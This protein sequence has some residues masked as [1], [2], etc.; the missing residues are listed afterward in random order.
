MEENQVKVVAQVNVNKDG[1]QSVRQ[2]PTFFV[3]AYCFV[4][5]KSIVKDIFKGQ[6]MSGQMEDSK[7]YMK[8]FNF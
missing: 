2:I 8:N 5:A 4:T 1:F 3:N 6:N 7:G